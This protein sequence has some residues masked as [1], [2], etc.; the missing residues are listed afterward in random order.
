M[1]LSGF[2]GRSGGA[3]PPAPV[4]YA[5]S[6]SRS[7]RPPKVWGR[8]VVEG[9]E[10]VVHVPGWRGL[11]AFHR[12]IAVPLAT[13]VDAAPDST[14]RGR[15]STKLIHRRRPKAT[16]L[17]RLGTYHGRSGWSFW[18]IGLGR[19]AVVVELSD[20]F[21]DFLIVEVA[22]PVHTARE[23]R[24]ACQALLVSGGPDRGKT[25]P[26]TERTLSFEDYVASV[27]SDAEELASRAGPW[28]DEPV[29]T[30]P[31][32]SVRDLLDHLGGVYLFWRAQVAAGVAEERT[33]LDA[34]EQAP[35]E[36]IVAWFRSSARELTD[37]LK[38]SDLEPGDPC[39]N[40]SGRD[41]TVGWVAR[42][43][44]LET[45]VHRFDFE[46][47][48]AALWAIP[49]EL[50]VD[51][52]DERL[53][54][55]LEADI[56]AAPDATLQGVLCLSCDDRADAWTVEVASGRVK[57]RYGRGP[58]DAV[59]V[60]S[61]S[62]LYLFTWNRVRIDRLELTGRRDVALAWESLPV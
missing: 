55:H 14:A 31:G 3:E 16:G 49:A 27:A 12:R 23:I 26:V 53:G 44:A 33:E 10:L 50:A 2:F 28:L 32:W 24:Q 41:T 22:D 20:G 62:D 29:P 52:V 57:W 11:A 45:A 42:R 38:A 54:V 25:A 4:D 7:N 60:G 19:N 34:G 36:D 47:A 51:G 18:S 48:T 61:A 15:V 37:L 40:W 30:C 8:L 13:V 58:A 9:D 21:Y 46:L 5:P 59:L 43:M 56:S 35:P 17:F 39:W 1:S 6:S